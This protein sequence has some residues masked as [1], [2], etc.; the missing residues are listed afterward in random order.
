MRHTLRLACPATLTRPSG[1]RIIPFEP[2]S[3]PLIGSLPAYPLGCMKTLAP[4]P[5]T[6]RSMLF[7]GISPNRRVPSC[8][9]TGPSVHLL[10]ASGY[11]LQLGVRPNQLLESWVELL[12]VLRQRGHGESHDT[13]DQEK[14]SVYPVRRHG[15]AKTA[16]YS[17]CVHVSSPRLSCC[18]EL[19]TN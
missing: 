10:K 7:A 19:S 17:K 2:G 11:A 9:Q 3:G 14:E 18:I 1:S 13:Y 12:N 8:V 5:G 4:L 16:A 6:H 15:A